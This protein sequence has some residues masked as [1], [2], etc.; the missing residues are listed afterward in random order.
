M[1]ALA[2]PR[3]RARPF[4]IAA[5]F[6]QTLAASC[7]TWAFPR[8]P[9]AHAAI[10]QNKSTHLQPPTYTITHP[11]RV[12]SSQFGSPFRFPNPELPKEDRENVQHQSLCTLCV[13]R[14]RRPA[15]DR[16]F[17]GP[18]SIRRHL[19]DGPFKNQVQP[20]TPHVLHKRGLVSLRQ[21]RPR[22]RRLRRRAGPRRLRPV[23]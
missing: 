13:C 8:N 4:Q 12:D 23:L 10:T 19:E 2:Q 11:G 1:I 3:G 16:V 14:S 7:L 9:F 17:S 15:R 22:L 20:K 18:V 5:I 6:A 21:L